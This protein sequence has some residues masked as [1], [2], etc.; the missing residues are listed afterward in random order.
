MPNVIRIK[1]SAVASKVPVTGDLQ[2]GELAINTFDGKLYTKK[3]NG[4]ASIVE[5]GGGG[6][7]SGLSQFVESESTAAPND[8]VP[9]DALTATDAAY[10]NIDV[11][12]AAKGSGATL[13]QIPDSTATG[14]NKRGTYVTDFQKTRTVSTQVASGN[15]S[16]IVGGS[17]NTASSGYAAVVGGSGNSVSGIYSFIGTGSS[18]SNSGSSSSIS[19]GYSNSI[20]STSSNS[21]IGSGTTNT[22]TG[23]TSVICGGEA[24]VAS[25][26][27]S[28]VSGGVYGTT[29]IVTGYH[30]FPACNSPIAQKAGASQAGLLILGRQTINATVTTLTSDSNSAWA[31]N[32]VVLPQNSAYVFKGTVVG[33]VTGG[34]AASG[35]EFS[36][37]IKR[38]SG[39]G[40]TAIVGSVVKNRIAYDS[41]ALDWDVNF[42]ADTTIGSLKVQVTGA[43][44]TTIRWVCKIE[45]T[46][47]TY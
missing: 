22:V 40:T 9:V 47:M 26:S 10:T 20:T 38:G 6:S 23:P 46:E 29:R 12:F 16:I 5:I 24:N 11:A 35:W 14:G 39:A 8:T 17:E 41:G 13:A 3:D 4:T 45:T 44:S 31:F 28:F 7:G 1:R 30:A 33:A 19:S 15:Y 34:G 43:A 36:G 27:L 42:T 25:G 21:F 2:L 32:Q 37:V 18:N